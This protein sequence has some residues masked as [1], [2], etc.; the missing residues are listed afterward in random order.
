MSEN[1]PSLA[2]SVRGIYRFVGKPN[3][4]SADA[5]LKNVAQRAGR[6]TVSTTLAGPRHRLG[7]GNSAG[8]QEVKA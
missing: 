7:V 1:W 4:E 6:E 2:R 3:S 8:R 5:F